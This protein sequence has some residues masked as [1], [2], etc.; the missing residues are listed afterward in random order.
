MPI[1]RTLNIGIV[2]H[3]DAGKTSLTERLLFDHGVIDALGSVDAGTTQTDS[4]DIERRRGITV[5]SAVVSFTVGRTH[6]NVID[7]PGHTDF[8][9]EVD[10]ALRVLDAAVLVVSAVEG[11]QAHARLLMRVLHDMRLP[12]LIFV[13]KVDRR[14]AR[15]R[16]LPAEIRRRLTPHAVVMNPPSDPMDVAETLAEQDD[17]ILARLIDGPPLEPEEL[18]RALRDQVGR[19][20]VHPVY[21]GSART[22]VGIDALVRAMV[23]LLPVPVTTEVGLPPRGTIFAI[24]RSPGGTKTAYLRLFSGT[25]AV[26]D[27][28]TL[29]RRDFDG[30]VHHHSGRITALEVVGHPAARLTAGNIGRITG[31]PDAR[32]GDTL[33]APADPDPAR[34][35]MPTLRTTVRV[36]GQAPARLH[37]ALRELAEQDPLLHVR[38]ESDGATSILLYGEIQRQIV[39]ATLAERYGI[40]AEFR[41]TEPL[42]VE[43]VTGTGEAVEAMGHR[44]PSPSGY[45]ATIGLRVEPAPAGTVFGYETELGA[46]PHAFHCAIEESVSATLRRGPHG[47]PI[48]GCVVTL[49]RSGFAGPVSTAADFRALTPLVLERALRRAGTKLLEPIHRFEAE[50]PADTLAP[51]SAALTGLGARIEDLTPA[52]TVRGT[53]PARH[54]DFAQRR[55]PGLTRGE[56]DWWSRPAGYR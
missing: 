40:D 13:N 1:H 31:I 16:E 5:R 30:I 38:V 42:C 12:T 41:S 14:G 8:V 32:V 34:V 26:R 23:E 24:D 33:G 7:T 17:S 10:R 3:V 37:A 25:L 19:G 36:R 15:T 6:I 29:H 54:A 50:I 9:A 11:V 49:I 46:L 53:I 21:F 20:I 44:A 51:V 52:W 2:A 18:R 27:R 48:T 45:W 56:A 4:G 47:R 22:G 39:A 43:Q 35:P 28:I 55:L